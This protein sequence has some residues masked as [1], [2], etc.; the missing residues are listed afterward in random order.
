MNQTRPIQKAWKIQKSVSFGLFTRELRAR[1]SHFR[2]GYIWAIAEPVSL[3]TVL[4]IVRIA[5]GSRDIAGI[6][7]P[8]FFASGIIPYLFFQNCTTQ[9]I[10]LVASNVA[11]MNYRRIKPIDPLISKILLEVII[12]LTTGIVVIFG[13]KCLGYSFAIKNIFGILLAIGCLI[14][15]TVGVSTISSILGAFVNETKKLL[16]ILIRPLFFISGIFFP[17][18]IIPSPYRE[19]LLLNPLLHVSELIREYTFEGYTSLHGNEMYLFTCSLVIL[20]LGMLTYRHKRI[21]LL[22]SGLIK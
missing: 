12:Y 21:E 16:P 14:L 3:I 15:I 8:L 19:V 11:L 6:Q 4:S 2:L 9:S 7:Y 13:L 17:A 5:I 18:S 10:S 20:Y 22:T 1:F